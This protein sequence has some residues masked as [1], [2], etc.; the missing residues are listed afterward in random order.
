[1]S[2][3]PQHWSEVVEQLLRPASD[4]PADQPPSVGL[5][6]LLEALEAYQRQRPDLAAVRAYN[7]QMVDELHG[8]RPLARQRLL[9][10]GASYCGFALERA[11]E[12][13]AALYVGVGLEVTDLEARG[14]TG[15]GRLLNANAE[16]LPFD[17]AS[18]DL[19]L[20]L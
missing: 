2:D 20:S 9:D 5:P 13:G 12:Q 6:A 4:G 17:D 8:L 19:A 3:R 7:R 18:F 10:L 16:A 11:L 1:M 14:A 15:R